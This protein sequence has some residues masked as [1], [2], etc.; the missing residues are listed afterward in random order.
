MPGLVPDEG[1]HGMKTADVV[2]SIIVPI[3]AASQQRYVDG[4]APGIADAAEYFVSHAC[5]PRVSA[6][7]S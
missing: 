3:T 6:A 5:K 2:R 4:L 1:G 7:Q